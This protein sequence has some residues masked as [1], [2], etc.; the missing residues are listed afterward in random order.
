MKRIPYHLGPLTLVRWPPTVPESLRKVCGGGRV[1]WWWWSR[2]IL[3]F[4]L[5]RAEQLIIRAMLNSAIIVYSFS[6]GSNIERI[7][8]PKMILVDWSCLKPLFTRCSS[9]GCCRTVRDENII[10]WTDGKTFILRTRLISNVSKQFDKFWL[11]H[12]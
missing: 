10:F 11:S 2:P 5:S 4:S 1:G 6:P 3:V 9:L 7:R 8:S 12:Q